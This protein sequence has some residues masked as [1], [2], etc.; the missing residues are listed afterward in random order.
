MTY[1]PSIPQPTDFISDSQPQ[2]LNNFTALNSVFSR[3]HVAFDVATNSGNHKFVELR[4]TAA[5]PAPIPAL[6]AGEGTIYTKMISSVS[7]LFYT[8]DASGNEYQL[9]RDIPASFSLFGTNTNNYNA[10]G[11][12]F[13]GG[14]SYLPGGLLIQYGNA[15][16]QVNGD[17]IPF[18]VAFTT[19]AFS[20][21]V[22]GHY[23][24]SSRG[25]WWVKTQTTTNFTVT[26]IDN[27]G[28]S[29]STTLYWFA[30]GK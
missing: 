10:S 29:I 18:P 9:T 7:Q 26:A 11:A 5:I 14:W 22:T 21:S 13:T 8:D 15:S 1:N 25:F 4:N 24:S 19:G 30:I 12:N 3:N 2:I 6:N 27:G 28:T 17:T 20:I 16:N 23:N